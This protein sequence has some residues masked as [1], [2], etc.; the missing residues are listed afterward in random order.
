MGFNE[1]LKLLLLEKSM[2]QAD[3][4]R[5]TGIQTSL[6]SEYING[7]KSPTIGNAILIADALNISLDDLVGRKWNTC[8]DQKKPGEYTDELSETLNKLTEKECIF[9]MD[10]IKALKQHLQW[11]KASAMGK[12]PGREALALSIYTYIISRS[13]TPL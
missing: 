6:M 2:K 8:R 12:R 3:L 1:N 11:K 10:V 9:V 5:M 13:I 4:C 7:R